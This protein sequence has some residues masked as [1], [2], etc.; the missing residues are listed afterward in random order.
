VSR[1]IDAPS[2]VTKPDKDDGMESMDNNDASWLE[3]R[4][5]RN[6]MESDRMIAPATK[7]A[8]TDR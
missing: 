3:V 5:Y 1:L 8:A 2:V 4:R 7:C 6:A